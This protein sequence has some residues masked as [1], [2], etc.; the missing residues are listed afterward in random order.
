M[1]SRGRAQT[2]PRG[3]SPRPGPLWVPGTATPESG[4][5]SSGPQPARPTTPTRRPLDPGVPGVSEG[6]AGGHRTGRGGGGGRRKGERFGSDGTH[7][8]CCCLSLIC[9]PS[10]CGPKGHASG[11][12]SIPH[13]RFM[14]PTA[15]GHTGV[16]LSPPSQTA[17]QRKR[18][19]SKDKGKRQR[20]I[21]PRAG[22]TPKMC[23]GWTSM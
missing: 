6:T 21:Q 9:Y 18:E 7:R 17:E 8:R 15:L 19:K 20:K 11:G 13:D 16:P 3:Q 1:G 12:F 23:S 2:P 14:P 10:A 5:G 4:L 22:H